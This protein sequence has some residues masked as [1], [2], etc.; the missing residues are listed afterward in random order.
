[1]S[2][3]GLYVV[4]V[5]F[6]AGGAYFEPGKTLSAKELASIRLF[7]IKLNEG[8]IVAMDNLSQEQFNYYSDRAK[9]RWD[10]DFKANVAKRVSKGSDSAGGQTPN[11]AATTPTGTQG[12]TA[13]STEG[14]T[15]GGPANNPSNAPTSPAGGAANAPQG[16]TGSKPMTGTTKQVIKPNTTNTKK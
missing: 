3:K 2:T 8:K 15:A 10:V 16:Q 1:M 4:V 11:A 12:S 6:K 9:L 14:S 5:P 7:K 13:G